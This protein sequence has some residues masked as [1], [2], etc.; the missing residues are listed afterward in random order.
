MNVLITGGLGFIGSKLVS[1]LIKNSEN[2]ICIVDNASIQDACLA[3]PDIN[4]WIGSFE[5]YPKSKSNLL[6]NKVILN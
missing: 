5:R 2:N 4:S 6:I 1:S 3:N